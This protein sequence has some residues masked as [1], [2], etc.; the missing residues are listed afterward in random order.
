L[1]SSAMRR[2]TPARCASV[3]LSAVSKRRM[4]RLGPGPSPPWAHGT[5]RPDTP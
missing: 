4:D 2:F 5:T 1:R 3:A